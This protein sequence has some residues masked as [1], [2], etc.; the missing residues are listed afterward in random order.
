MAAKP[1]TL[2]FTLGKLFLAST[3]KLNDI[4]YTAWSEFS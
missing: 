4:V 1:V 3:T 2:R